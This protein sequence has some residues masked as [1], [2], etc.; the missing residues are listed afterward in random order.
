V[1]CVGDRMEVADEGKMCRADLEFVKGS[2]AESGR[3]MVPPAHL[4][5][6]YHPRQAG[7]LTGES[8][9][10]LTAMIQN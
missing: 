1:P 10:S 2:E 4:K 3:D 8:H 9:H 5:I 7:S 6:Y